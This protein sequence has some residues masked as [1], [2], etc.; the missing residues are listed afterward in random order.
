MSVDLT[1]SSWQRSAT[2]RI[3]VWEDDDEMRELLFLALTQDGAHV[4]P[5]LARE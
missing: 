4:D 2:R 3:L 5:G 1:V